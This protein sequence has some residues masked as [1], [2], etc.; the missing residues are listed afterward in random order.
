MNRSERDAQIA[1][2]QAADVDDDETDEIEAG[3]AAVAAG[4]AAVEAGAAAV[5]SSE[6]E[7]PPVPSVD[8]VQSVIESEAIADAIRI[9]AQ[10]DADVQR[11]E[12]ETA[13]RLQIQAAETDGQL[14]VVDALA[15]DEP[16]PIVHE[17]DTPP[18]SEHW[19]FKPRFGGR[20]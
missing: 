3:A 11:I 1:A 8:E 7:Q 16:A 18:K 12:A 20:K 4:A 2:L 10:A 15:V 17:S 14:A 13:A 9:Q 5:E 6:P 19:F